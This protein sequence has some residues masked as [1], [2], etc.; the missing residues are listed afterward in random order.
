MAKPVPL[1][2]MIGLIVKEPVLKELGIASD[3]AELAEIRKTLKPF[4][5][6]L[7]QRLNHPTDEDR[8]SRLT[9][10]DLYARIEAEFVSELKQKLKPDQFVRLQQIHWQRWGIRSI[11]DEQVAETL[12]LSQDQQAS[13]AAV[14]LDYQ[15]RRKEVEREQRGMPATRSQ[16]LAD[17]D[18]EQLEKY[19]QILTADQLAK[20]EE[21]KGKPFELVE[22]KPS[23]TNPPEMPIR[24]HPGGLIS[25]V[26]MEPVLKELGIDN[27]SPQVEELSRLSRAHA[28]DLRQQLTSENGA[29]NIRERARLIESNLQAKYDPELKKV[30]TPEQMRRLQEIYFQQLGTQAFFDADVVKTLQISREQQSKAEELIREALRTSRDLLNP[31]GGGRT[32]GEPVSPEDQKQIQA[33]FEEMN[34][35]VTQILTDAQREKWDELKG[36]PFDLTRLRRTPTPR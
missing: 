30:L 15:S 29:K 11:E 34:S 13:L 20:F 19:K 6:V 22:S 3:S 17:L 14:K 5:T 8:A 2:G 21:L 12:Q 7:Q 4:S 18:Q 25:L 28:Q 24:T 26:V 35:K 16:K 32:V 33:A 31:P 27:S 23:T 36:K 9:A 10:Q 1:V